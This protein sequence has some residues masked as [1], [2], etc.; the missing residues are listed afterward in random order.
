MGREDPGLLSVWAVYSGTANF[1]WKF[2]SNI[3]TQE[4]NAR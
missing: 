1:V 2:I 3:G 4:E